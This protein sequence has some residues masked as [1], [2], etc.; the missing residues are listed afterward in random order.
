M[1]RRGRRCV[2]VVLDD[3][4][5]VL[6]QVAGELTAEDMA[7]LKECFTEL[8]KA[9]QKANDGEHERAALLRDWPWR[10]G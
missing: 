1:T 5:T 4:T 9:A 6:A 8:R 2:P 3:G 10:V 7:V